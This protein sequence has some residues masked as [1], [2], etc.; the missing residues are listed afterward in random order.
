M[1]MSD[2]KNQPEQLTFFAEEHPVNHSAL[3]ASE[4]DWQTLVATWPSTFLELLMTYAPG[5]LY[6][7]TSP[8]SCRATEDGTLV[9]FSGRWG[10]SG[11]GSPIECW[12]LN[13]SEFHKDAAV[14]SLSD[15]LEAGEVPQRYY[16]TPKACAGILRRA[17]KRGKELPEE[18]RRALEAVSFAKT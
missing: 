18:L 7:K 4:K 14:C 12:T 15:I 6:G 2:T 9:P 13:T 16:L 3:P 11:M 8:A 10:N 5:G 1:K 17:E